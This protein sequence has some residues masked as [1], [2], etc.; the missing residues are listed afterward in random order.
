MVLL[1][2]LR[3]SFSLDSENNAVR[4]FVFKDLINRIKMTATLKTLGI[5]WLSLTLV[6]IF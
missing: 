6:D 5:Y 4:K 3:D 2:Y 1:C